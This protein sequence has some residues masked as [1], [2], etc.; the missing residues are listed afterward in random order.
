MLER[1]ARGEYPQRP[2]TA[3]RGPSIEGIV[4]ALWG[5]IWRALGRGRA[6]PYGPALVAGPY[7]AL[8]LNGLLR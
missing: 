6:F 8:L 2:H 3:F 1:I 4:G 5:V 7:L